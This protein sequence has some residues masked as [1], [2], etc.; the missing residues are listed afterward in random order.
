MFLSR[1]ES[2]HTKLFKDWR[3]ARGTTPK[4]P[5]EEGAGTHFI[6][7]N[8]PKPWTGSCGY[9]TLDKLSQLC[10]Y[11]MLRFHTVAHFLLHPLQFLGDSRRVSDSFPGYGG[12]FITH[13]GMGW[14]WR[15]IGS[16]SFYHSSDKCIY[17]SSIY[18]ICNTQTITIPIYPRFTTGT[19]RKITKLRSGE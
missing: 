9:F 5:H 19:L 2:R 15:E 3:Q 4:S 16:V 6:W 1:S 11:V 7:K 13:P 10:R 18:I 14:D 17:R 12:T 8:P